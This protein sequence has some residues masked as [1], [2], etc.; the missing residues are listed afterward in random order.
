M[1]SEK[2]EVDFDHHSS[3]FVH[4]NYELYRRMRRECPVAHTANYGGFWVVTGYDEVFQVARD[5]HTFSSRGGGVVPPTN[6]GRLLPIQVDPPELQRHRHLLHPFMTPDAVKAL[7]PF[8]EGAADAA[9]DR[10]IEVGCA[11]LVLDLANP[12]PAMT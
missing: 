1:A 3:D 8:I 11:D 6:V 4:N 2:R 12:V 7:E 9:I 10:F 5:D